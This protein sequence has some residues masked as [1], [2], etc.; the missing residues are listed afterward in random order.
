MCMCGNLFFM[1]APH[2]LVRMGWNVAVFQASKYSLDA[3]AQGAAVSVG[4]A[5]GAGKNGEGNTS[6]G[7]DDPETL[8]SEAAQ[9]GA[10]SVLELMDERSEE[11]EVQRYACESL[12]ELCAGNGAW[13]VFVST[14]VLIFS[15][16]RSGMGR[17]SPRW[18]AQRIPFVWCSV[19]LSCS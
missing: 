14:F 4:R 17:Y 8:V 3:H 19:A 2:M 16:L 15:S 13:N 12:A 11:M 7:S 10:R 9:Q 6:P 18:S 1:I 5:D